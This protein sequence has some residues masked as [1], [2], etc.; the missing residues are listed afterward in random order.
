[1]KNLS[2]IQRYSRLFYH[3]MTVLLMTLPLYFIAYWTL[4]NYLPSTGVSVNIAPTPLVENPLSTT[5]QLIGLF[6]GL[7]PLTALLY[8]V[9][10]IRKLFFLYQKGNIFSFQHVVIFKNIAKAFFLWTLASIFYESAKSVLFSWGNP[11]GQR[12]LE[13][14]IHSTEII[15]L[16]IGLTLIVISW[17]MDEGR[18]LQEEQQLTV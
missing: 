17:V 8:G 10:N 12:V 4:I 7:F 9:G 1:M 18:I 6:C 14:G 13:V 2:K 15:Q 5:L 3:L 11:P 16:F